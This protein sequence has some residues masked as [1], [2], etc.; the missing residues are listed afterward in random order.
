MSARAVVT[1]YTGPGSLVTALPLENV[2][3]L[4]FD[5][6]DNM[7]YIEYGSP[8]QRFA[9]SYNGIATVTVTISGG[10][11]TFTIS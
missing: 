5:I 11:T 3:S 10:V 2:V 4:E 7:I 8:K 6:A 1:G 9:L